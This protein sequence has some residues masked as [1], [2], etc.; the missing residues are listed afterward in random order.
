MSLVHRQLLS[1]F[2]RILGTTLVG[3]L[4]LFT[5][6]DMLDHMGSFL[7]N[8]ATLGM[9]GRYYLYKVP[10]II[11]TVLP[12]AMLMATLFTVGSM[13]RYYELTALF[14]AGRSLM[15]VT[16]PLLL[17]AAVT[18]LFS[19][20][21]S[22]FVLPAANS[23]S[24]RIWEV[25]VHRKPDRSR[26]TSDIALTGEDG[27][28]YYARTFVPNQNR[29]K[30]MRVHAFSGAEVTERYDAREAEWDGSQ[31]ILRDGTRR[32]FR[33]G[34][35]ESEAFTELASGLTGVTPETFRTERVRPENMNARRLHRLIQT[36]KRG[37]N[38]ASAYEVDLQF[39]LAFPAVHLIVVFLGIL[40]ASGP[41]KTTIASGFGWTI[42][43]SF[44]YYLAMNF[45]RALGHS[46]ALP[47]LPAAW[48]GNLAY[49]AMG[50]GLFIKARR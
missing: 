50:M 9:M 22:E 19:L 17:M 37:G 24:R 44:G 32:T 6:V 16:R 5:L 14:A 10:W 11:D 13:A 41:R 48:V 45:G 40:L 30:G 46:G 25:E 26:P 21:W 8:D 15:Q 3:A 2:L 1:S 4:V 43:I 42:M 49:A 39:K 47:P 36:L 20:A 7:D 38:D 27:R 31:W 35:E 29:I 33:G 23:A 18:A 12:I 28:L 34:R